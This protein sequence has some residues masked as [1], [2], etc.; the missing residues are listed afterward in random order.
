MKK[1]TNWLLGAWIS[2]CSLL[3]VWP[4]S[5]LYVWAMM[6]DDLKS[7]LPPFAVKAVS[8]S[9]MLAG[10]LGKMHGMRKENR[11]LRNDVDSR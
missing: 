9:I 6:P 8:Y 3:Q 11:R 10:I 4:E 1:L 5:M 7:A 2:F